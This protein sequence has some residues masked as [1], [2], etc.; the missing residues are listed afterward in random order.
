M[1]GQRMKKSESLMTGVRCPVCNARPGRPC[2]STVSAARSRHL[3][4]AHEERSQLARRHRDEEL[5]KLMSTETYEPESP[6]EARF[7][8]EYDPRKYPVTVVTVDAVIF[9]QER[10]G[11]EPMVLLVQR[12][13]WPYRG[14]WA[15]PGGFINPDETSR[16]AVVRELYE[17]TGVVV[18]TSMTASLGVFDEPSRDPRGR[19]ISI[20]YAAY[21]EELPEP[22]AGDDAGQARWVEVSAALNDYILAF[23][24]K[25]IVRKAMQDYV[26]WER[27]IT[28]RDSDG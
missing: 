13:G 19:A 4:I 9:A 28:G 16:E 3:P 1:Q 26:R 7:L 12:A 21:I 17:E 14:Y 25:A 10:P 5:F 24:H 22:K 23:D 11:Q 27:T 6:Q 20:A 2:R 8:H 15:L 18:S